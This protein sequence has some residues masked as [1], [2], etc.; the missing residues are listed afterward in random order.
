M[1]CHA[2][3]RDNN[4]AGVRSFI[5]AGNDINVQDS[6]RRTPLHLAAWTGNAAMVQLL[7]DSKAS[8]KILGN[9]AI[10]H[11]LFKR[12]EIIGY[13]ILV[14][15]CATAQD[16]FTALHFACVSAGPAESI[17]EVISVLVKR[18][19]T[20]L[21][22]RV[23][24]GNKTALHMAA[25]KGTLAVVRA[26]LE[27][28]ADPLAKSGSGETAA[29]LAR[30]EDV[31]TFIRSFTAARA[32]GVDK[33]AGSEVLSSALE[34]PTLLLDQAGY[35]NANSCS[36]TEPDADASSISIRTDSAPSTVL[37]ADTTASVGAVDAC[38]ED[39]AIPAGCVPGP[40]LAD[41]LGGG[42]GGVPVVG[43]EMAAPV[44]HTSSERLE[45]M[46]KKQRVPTMSLFSE[47]C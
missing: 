12:F 41:P 2:A 44:A 38:R 20:L 13:R 19:K 21:H 36:S 31:S 1:E 45:P 42:G 14:F 8:T 29:S 34:A 28:G 25:A 3:I 40:L 15:F 32:G 11:E 46:K 16:G 35:S 37:G 4:I 6:M 47:D 9:D 7:V 27:G 10:H 26:L 18:D 5:A 30:S 43:P 17:V 39:A 33:K 23:K 24:K 22:A